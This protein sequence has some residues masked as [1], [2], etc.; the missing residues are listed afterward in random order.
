MQEKEF[1]KMIDNILIYYPLF[2]RKIKTSIYHEKRSK[3]SKPLGY[4]QVL[5]TLM[6]RGPL[7]I[8][9]IGR[10]LYISK[11]N[12]T[13]LIDKLVKDGTARR[14]RSSEDR[15]IIN[16]EITDEGRNFMFD[17]RKV[18][19]E[20]IQ[21]NLSNLNKDELKVLNDSLENIKNL[22]LKINRE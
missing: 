15:R 1:E 19:E 21:E 5:G 22:F 9:E 12:M 4:Y 8:S 6:D 2:F 14:S 18:V 7:S 16:V 17:A 13:S 3:Y 20:N 11:P 10:I